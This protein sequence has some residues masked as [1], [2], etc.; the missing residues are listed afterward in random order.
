[1]PWPL[2]VAWC[3]LWSSNVLLGSSHSSNLRWNFVFEEIRRL[4]IKESLA[5]MASNVVLVA[6]VAEALAATLQLFS[7][8]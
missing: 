8:R 6:V 5:H 7:W 3:I 2:L 4:Q 1:V